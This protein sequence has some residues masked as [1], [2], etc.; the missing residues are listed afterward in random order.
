[1]KKTLLNISVT[2]LPVLSGGTLGTEMFK[3]KCYN[4]VFCLYV[5]AGCF[6]SCLFIWRL[7]FISSFTV[8]LR[9]KLYLD[10]KREVWMM[11]L[12]FPSSQSQLSVCSSVFQLELLEVRRQQEEEERMRKPPSPEPLVIQQEESQQQR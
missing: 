11:S 4:S 7:R 9:C 2:G 1:M 12:I 10:L 3:L 6:H 5:G 8:N